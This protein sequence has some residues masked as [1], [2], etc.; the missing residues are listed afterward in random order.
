MVDGLCG[1]RKFLETEVE[2]ELQSAYNVWIEHDSTSLQHR[3]QKEKEKENG[4]SSGIDSDSGINRSD[5]MEFGINEY[6]RNTIIQ[7]LV[8]V[9]IG[10][11]NTIRSSISYKCIPKELFYIRVLLP[12]YEDIKTA[13]EITLNAY[14]NHPVLVNLTRVLL[15][16][17]HTC[18][19]KSLYKYSAVYLEHGVKS[20]YTYMCGL[21]WTISCIKLN[22]GLTKEWIGTLWDMFQT[23]RTIEP[24]VLLL[25]YYVQTKQWGMIQPLEG[26]L[27]SR[28]YTSG[29]SV[30]TGTQSQ[31]PIIQF[32][33]DISY[34]RWAL[35]RNT[36][37]HSKIDIRTY[38]MNK[39]LIRCPLPT[40]MKHVYS[41]EHL[42]LKRDMKNTFMDRILGK[43]LIVIHHETVFSWVGDILHTPLGGVE[44]SIVYLSRQWVKDGKH[45]IVFCNT[46]VART[47]D[48]VEF[49]PINDFKSIV[50]RYHVHILLYVNRVHSLYYGPSINMM[51]VWDQTFLGID[52]PYESITANDNID[53]IIVPSHLH[54]VTV[55]E[56]LHNTV[57]D[58]VTLIPFGVNEYSYLRRTGKT[59]P[60]RFIYI[61]EY[62]LDPFLNVLV[63]IFPIIH[64]KY[65]SVSLV[66]LSDF[67]PPETMDLCSSYDFIE[68]M[69]VPCEREMARQIIEAE[70]WIHIPEK[71][72][73]GYQLVNEMMAGKVF[74]IT[75]ELCSLYPKSSNTPG[76]GVSNILQ[77]VYT[78]I[79]EVEN[80]PLHNYDIV[81]G[82]YGN[83]IEQTWGSVFEYWVECIEQTQ[84]QKLHVTVPVITETRS[85]PY[86]TLH[87]PHNHLERIV[88]TGDNYPKVTEW[89]AEHITPSTT[90]LDIGSYTGFYSIFVSYIAKSVYAYDIHPFYISMLIQ[91][92]ERLGRQNI[93]VHRLGLHKE[94]I[95]TN[96]IPCNES[97]PSTSILNHTDDKHTDE[98]DEF[99]MSS[100][101]NNVRCDT[102]DRLFKGRHSSFHHPLVVKI[103]VNKEEHL[104]LK[105]SIDFI[106]EFKPIVL[107]RQEY[108]RLLPKKHRI[109][110]KCDPFLAVSFY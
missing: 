38:E 22:Y 94:H 76:T 106:M 6:V 47:I 66:I 110:S 101:H 19:Y 36:S 49:I 86:T 32:V 81:K 104:V 63:S 58:L 9:A 2:T 84:Q 75:P 73:A 72:G 91:N 89:L 50:E 3:I 14:T 48:Q 21:L 33:S 45:C 68:I 80:N 62:K 78:L 35:I 98:K 4:S 65:P 51:Y 11:E 28:D 20:K 108:I 24:I 46:P 18:N 61:E 8:L 12:E 83:A 44:R 31:T 55:T 23:Y 69:G 59:I 92:K 53:G 57:R 7:K 105:G 64:S 15:Y 37:I 82:H 67:V 71:Q 88:T 10:D 17:Y 52:I 96:M 77:L 85:F 103:D 42:V 34:K 41:Y 40:R 109:I 1:I 26:I 27:M 54:S 43:K 79:Q 95:Y 60:M 97:D 100:S 25:E 29:R 93:S 99:S 13:R 56:R 87:V 107:I 90:F 70:F 74:C 102:L 39:K 5:S 16:E 30:V